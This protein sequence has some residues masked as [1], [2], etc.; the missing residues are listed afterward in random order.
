MKFEEWAAEHGIDSNDPNYEL[1]LNCW[2]QAQLSTAQT[3]AELG[4]AIADISRFVK[5][6][7]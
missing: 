1:M 6:K 3:I 2:L 7:I 4:P 5:E